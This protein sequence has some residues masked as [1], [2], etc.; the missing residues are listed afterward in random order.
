MPE[1]PLPKGGLWGQKAEVSAGGLAWDLFPLSGHPV[2]CVS[3]A[4]AREA[5]SWKLWGIRL[6]DLVLLP[7]ALLL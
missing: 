1:V 5:G 4:G 3:E 7:G 2:S 6:Q